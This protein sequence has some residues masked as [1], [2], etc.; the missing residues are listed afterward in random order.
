MCW[1]CSRRRQLNCGVRHG[2]WW[3]TLN[4]SK[5][6]SIA[7]SRRIGKCSHSR[8]TNRRHVRNCVNASP[9]LSQTRAAG[10]DPRKARRGLCRRR[11]ATQGGGRVRG[12]GRKQE[13]RGG[14]ARGTVAG[15]GTVRQGRTSGQRGGGV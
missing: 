1:H 12:A 14:V 9:Q 8:P 5:G 13:G 4:F 3:R 7:P 6:R 2:P 11:A 10:G 15:G